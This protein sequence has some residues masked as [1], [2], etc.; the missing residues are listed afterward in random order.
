M[1]ASKEGAPGAII[2]P[3]DLIVDDAPGVRHSSIVL[4]G[5]GVI[6]C[7]GSCE[8]IAYYIDIVKSLGFQVF[9]DVICC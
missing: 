3:T 4:M 5:K 2:F 7:P 1:Q 9:V 8:G 6:A